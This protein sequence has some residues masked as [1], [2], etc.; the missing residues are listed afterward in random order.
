MAQIGTK[1]A[2]LDLLIRQGATFGPVNVSATNPDTTPLNLTGA[3][4]RA[5]IRKTPSSAT[6]DATAVITMVDAA[7]GIFKFEFTAAETTLMTASDSGETDPLS[8]YVWD[9]EYVDAGT[10]VN[11]LMYGT[12]NVFR[13]VTK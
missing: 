13:E 5:Q 8:T 9:M 10:K 7:N 6:I 11:P 3:T 2:L 12:V 1:G 4:V